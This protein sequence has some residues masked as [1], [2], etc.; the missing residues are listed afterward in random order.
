MSSNDSEYEEIINTI[1]MPQSI[2]YV[3]EEKHHDE[4]DSQYVDLLIDD[5]GQVHPPHNYSQMV[6]QSLKGGNAF[7]N[8]LNSF[9]VSASVLTEFV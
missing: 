9:E 8:L 3:A 6:W 5:C 2:S 4:D 1:K 7:T